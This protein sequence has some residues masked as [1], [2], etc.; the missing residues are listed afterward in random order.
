MCDIPVLHNR[1]K[2][3]PL[4]EVPGS[5]LRAVHAVQAAGNE[6]RTGCR[7][8]CCNGEGVAGEEVNCC[9][10][11]CSPIV[12]KD[13]SKGSVHRGPR[14]SGENGVASCRIPSSMVLSTSLG[15]PSRDVFFRYDISSFDQ[16]MHPWIVCFRWFQAINRDSVPGSRR[17][18]PWNRRISCDPLSG[19]KQLPH[20]RRY[21]S[22]PGQGQQMPAS[23]R[24]RCPAALHAPLVPLV[25]EPLWWRPAHL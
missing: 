13:R 12:A 17:V 1:T 14:E 3:S 21:P 4:R 7:R 15:F 22:E 20:T 23:V 18:I 25:V 19:E 5:H 6:R 8:P 2:T 16:Q 24:T 10:P 9:I 11:P